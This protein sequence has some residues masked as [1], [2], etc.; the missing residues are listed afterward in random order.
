MRLVPAAIAVSLIP[1]TALAE[2]ANPAGDVTYQVE[3][4]VAS[5]YVARAQPQYAGHAPCSQNAATIK[6]DHV[7]DGALS[8]GV[9]NAVALDHY[10]AQPGTALEIDA[11]ASYGWNQGPVALT[12]GLQSYL[13]PSHAAGTPLDGA[14]EAFVTASWDNPYVVPNAQ[15]WVEVVH[16]QGVYLSV[17]GSHDFHVGR[18]TLSPAV[19]V[20]GATYRKYL[21][22][23]VAAAPHLND[24]T[25]GVNARV[26]LVEGVYAALRGSYAY[27]GTP[28]ELMPD[29]DMDFSDRST[30]VGVVALGITR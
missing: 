14:H 1:A 20:G 12:A 25:A 24:V 2:Q 17:G 13:F 7:G 28:S 27:R 3:T 6:I 18:V 10:G 4:S 22:A 19:S 26:E 9:W 21:G 8:V 11:L 16:Q 30:V 29:P 5:D 23:P 15:A